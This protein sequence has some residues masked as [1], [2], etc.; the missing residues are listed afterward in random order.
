MCAPI[1]AVGIS[2]WLGRNHMSEQE[3][4]LGLSGHCN[5]ARLPRLA[6]KTFLRTEENP[7]L[8]LHPWEACQPHHCS[9]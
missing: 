1:L 2:V 7:T 3:R 6:L 5:S 8:H 9:A 4:H